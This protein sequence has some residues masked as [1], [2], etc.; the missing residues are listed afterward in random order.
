MFMLEIRGHQF[1][2]TPIPLRC[3]RPFRIEDVS[4]DSS[5]IDP[6]TSHLD[7]QIHAFLQSRIEAM[8]TKVKAA[9]A[10]LPPN[11]APPS[12]MSVPLV[13][14]KVRHS[15]GHRR[16]A[17]CIAVPVLGAHGLVVLVVLI[18]IGVTT[19]TPVIIIVIIIVIITIICRWSTADTR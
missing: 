3:V 15:I 4:L 18:A 16:A 11:L 14:L 19:I 5:G 6:S 12:F 1:R 8:V 9:T 2:S 13:R 7:D 10:A 17:I